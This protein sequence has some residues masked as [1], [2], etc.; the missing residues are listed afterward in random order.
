LQ[1]KRAKARYA[2]GGNN[3]YVFEINNNSHFDQHMILYHN[4][5]AG[6]SNVAFYALPAVFTNGEFYS[7]LPNLLAKTFLVD[8][9]HISPHFVDMSPHKLHLFP[10]LHIAILHSENETKVKAISAE[11]FGKLIAEGKI[12]IRISELRENMMRAPKVD[13]TPSSKRPRFTL[14]MFP[15][16]IRPDQG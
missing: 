3:V 8:V 2:I 7:S 6:R 12:G 4:L 5:A 14:N 11:E 16:S 13:L 10:H 1:Y 9:S 15:A